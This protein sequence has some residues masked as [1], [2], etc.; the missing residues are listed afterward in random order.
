M[1]S[2]PKT[3][4][5]FSTS[6]ASKITSSASFMSL[7][8][9]TDKAGNA[10]SGLYGFVV[11]KGSASE[12]FMLGTVSGTTVTITARGLDPSD[13]KTEVSALKLSH[14]RGA[15]VDI[16]D[17]PLL[18]ILLRLLNADESFPNKLKYATD[19]TF[20][21]DKELVAKK[22]VDGVA[23]AGAPDA[24]TGTK[25]I[26]KMSTAPVSSTNPIAVGDNDTRVP[27]Q[28]ENDGLAATTIP[29]ST[30]LFI[31]QKDFQ[32]G[33]EISGSTTGSANAYVFTP[34]PAIAA[35][36]AGM[37]FRLKANF[38]NSGAATLN[39]SGLGAVAIK[40]LNGATALLSGD[41]ASGQEFIVIHDGTNFQLVSPVANQPIYKTGTT[42]RAGTTASGSQTIAHG[43]G[44]V[45]KVVRITVR[46]LQSAANNS[47]IE[48]TG[49]YDGTNTACVFA[50]DTSGG[51]GVSSTNIIVM[52]DNGTTNTQVATISVDATNITLTWTKAGTGVTNTMNI[53]W[54]ALA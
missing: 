28:G 1:A 40:K 7:V 3:S 23:I 47:N 26:V 17:Y 11:D 8:S 29:A 24:A 14:R 39:V 6:L 49:A 22:Y 50:T 30:N 19:L 43:L 10:L 18:A 44:F 36:A 15:T 45:P 5:H 48:S 16:T 21:D 4:A 41:I 35:Y 13:G 52:N 37:T 31:T 20:T 38:T 25:G 32:K 46:A 9:G 27:T 54:E 12:E 2:I 51:T 34:S 53:L 33:A 42:T